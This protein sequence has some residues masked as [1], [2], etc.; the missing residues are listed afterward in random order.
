L[1]GFRQHQAAANGNDG[2]SGCKRRQPVHLHPP[3]DTRLFV[4]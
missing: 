1:L 3:Y 2:A 4:R